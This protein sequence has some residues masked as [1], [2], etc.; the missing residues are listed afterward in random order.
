[1]FS[2]SYNLMKLII[3][4]QP[5][6]LSCPCQMLNKLKRLFCLAFRHFYSLKL[7]C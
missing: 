5:L 4:L 7:K 2:T 6:G 1:M 3:V